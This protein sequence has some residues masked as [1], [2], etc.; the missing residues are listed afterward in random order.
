MLIATAAAFAGSWRLALALG[1]R[2]G[3]DVVTAWLLILSAQ[4]CMLVLVVGLARQLR[5][6]PL[7]VAAGATAIVQVLFSATVRRSTARECSRRLRATMMQILRRPWRHPLLLTLGLL[8]SAVY[9][10]RL[11]VAVRLPTLDFDGNYYHLISVDTW[12]QNGAVT[13]TPQNIFADTY[14]QNSELITAWSATFLHSTW[15]AGLTQFLFVAMGAAAVMGLAANAGSGRWRAV[16]AGMVFAATPIVFL[17][18]GTAYVDIAASA[19][20]LAT[21]QVLL[22][23]HD[24]RQGHARRSQLGAYY[25]VVGLG[26]GMMLGTKG[27]NIVSA[28]LAVVLAAAILLARWR[29]RPSGALATAPAAPA[30]PREP[31]TDAM[32]AARGGAAVLVSI[33]AQTLRTTQGESFWRYAALPLCALTIPALLVG[34]YWYARNLVTYGNPVWPVT[35]PFFQGRGTVGQLLAVN[36]PPEL[37]K[38]PP[39]SQIGRSWIADLAPHAYNYDQRL[40]GFGPQWLLLL[41]PSIAVMVF[42]FLRDRL[43]YLVGLMVPLVTLLFLRPEPWWSRYTVFLAGLGAVCFVLA[44]KWLAG[45]WERVLHWALVAVVALGMWGANSPTE[46]TAGAPARPLTLGHALALLRADQGTRAYALYPW[47]AFK[48][49]SSAPPGAVVAIPDRNKMIFTHPY[50]G[51]DLKRRLVVIPTPRNEPML[52]TSLVAAGADYVVLDPDTAPTAALAKAAL[53]DPRLHQIG[54]VF[55][56]LLFAVR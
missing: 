52:Y 7:A 16:F 53:R 13:H 43:V 34:G 50:I 28:A 9:A 23:A 18:A 24:A 6:V 4:L 15:L 22:S 46:I 36:A 39:L 26:I 41:A 11:A 48:P 14:P 5:P 35:V 55:D 1:L 21:W 38:L 20:I 8:V 42:G 17:Q 27:S 37:Q 32:P 10:W 54:F 33:P 45:R 44:L 29:F 40:G 30:L 12:V 19:T 47:S 2:R 31:E 49:L 25:A 3:V 56:G 51:T